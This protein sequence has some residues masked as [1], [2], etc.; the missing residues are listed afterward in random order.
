MRKIQQAGGLLPLCRLP[1]EQ[2]NTLLR[3]NFIHIQI[4][5][6]LLLR[7]GFLKSL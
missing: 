7:A 1:R 2:Q 4:A 5:L 3:R 6:S